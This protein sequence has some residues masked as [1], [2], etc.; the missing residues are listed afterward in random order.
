MTSGASSE[1]LSYCRPTPIVP[2]EEH[3]VAIGKLTLESGESLAEPRIGFVTHGTL[4]ALGVSSA[5]RTAVL[6][7]VRTFNESGIPGFDL[8][9]W[10][11]WFAPKGTPPEIVDKLNQEI[12]AVLADPEIK[13]KMRALGYEPAGTE[14]PQKVGEFVRAET[15]KW[16]G[17]VKSAGL[18]GE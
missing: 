5:G 1:T 4:N 7:N 14:S 16:G 2:G 12:R 15:K 13:A 10:N 17:L 6:P 18:K 3:S 11:V 8:S 9:A